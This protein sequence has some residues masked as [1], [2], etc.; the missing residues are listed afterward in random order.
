VKYFL[1]S[2]THYGH[3]NIIGYENRPFRDCDHMNSGLIKNWNMRVTD[4]DTVF[5][6]G[7]FCFKS[8]KGCNKAD[9]WMK[10]LKGQKILVRGNHDVNNSA[11]TIIDGIRIHFANHDIYLCHKPEHANPDYEINFIGH[12]HH[13]WR[14]RSFQQ[15]YD[16][17]EGLIRDKKELEKD[18]PDLIPFLEKHVN[19]RNSQSILLNVGVDVQK[20]MPITI[21]EALGQVIKFKKEFYGH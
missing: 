8:G 10:Q 17:I 13:N 11:K 7:D 21:D 18:R 15:H 9:F 20:Y 6:L 12:V 2:D 4:D 16:I 5:I 3:S 14:I 1:T 19:K